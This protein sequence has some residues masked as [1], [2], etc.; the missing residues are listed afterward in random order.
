MPRLPALVLAL[1]SFISLACQ[2]TPAAPTSLSTTVLPTPIPFAAFRSVTLRHEGREP[3]DVSGSHVFMMGYPEGA[4]IIDIATGESELLDSLGSQAWNVAISE[5]YVAWI[6][7]VSGSQELFLMERET[8]EVSQITQVPAERRSLK[9]YGNRLVWQDR[10]NESDEHYTHFDIYAYDID[11]GHEI[12]ITVAPGAQ[13]NPDIHGNIVVWSDN[14][15]SPYMGTHKAGCDNCAD[16]RTDIYLYD[17]DSG[18]ERPIVQSGAL[19]ASPSIHGRNLAWQGFDPERDFAVIHLIDLDTGERREIAQ[20][21]LSHSSPAVLD[22]Y[23]IWAVRWACDI[24]SNLM[25]E[26]TGLYAYELDTGYVYRLSDYV[27]P[28]A[29]VDDRVV[30]IH[31]GCHR[32]S[33]VYA[34]FL[35]Q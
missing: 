17:F 5:E 16:N 8:G 27:E 1:L 26:N 6:E 18:E 12:P 33:R 28:R 20:V 31:E 7:D 30:V 32:V 9:I 13:R 14:R 4:A 11:L 23:V 24:V 15:H 29:F 10:R 19:N 35:E 25:P 3:M 2:D 34:I 22:G 21:P